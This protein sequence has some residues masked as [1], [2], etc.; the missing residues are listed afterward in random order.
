MLTDSVTSKNTLRNASAMSQCLLTR[1]VARQAVRHTKYCYKHSD[2]LLK[3][4]IRK[5]I[6]DL[7]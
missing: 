3:H 4:S 7:E 1:D 2:R 5:N 6:N